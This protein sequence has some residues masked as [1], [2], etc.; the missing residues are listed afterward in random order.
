MSTIKTTYLQH[1]SASSPNLT[2]ASDGTVSGG[3]GLG[4]LVHI[5]TE[6]FSG[7]S[8][9]SLDNVFSADYRN[10]KL[11]MNL[12]SSASVYFYLRFRSAGTDNTSTNYND[13]RIDANNTVVSAQRQNAVDKA[14]IFYQSPDEGGGLIVEFLDP[15]LPRATGFRVVSIST[16]A[17]AYIYDT[18]GS[19]SA[20]NS[21]DGFSIFGASGT[22]TGS[23]AIYGYANS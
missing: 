18:A 4:G 23:A 7:V 19:F 20:T 2:L 3:A 22:M 14:R 5:A 9:V 6:S 13:Q 16:Y 15:Q 17:D 10:Y 21:F 1:P 8:S 11:F 12:Q